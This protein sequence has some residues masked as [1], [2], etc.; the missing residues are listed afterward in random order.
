[1]SEYSQGLST[2]GATEAGR[3]VPFAVF[4]FAQPFHSTHRQNDSITVGCAVSQSVSY[5][6]VPPRSHPSTGSQSGST[7]P[8][9]TQVPSTLLAPGG[10][11]I[12]QL[13]APR[14]S[15]VRSISPSGQ[16]VVS[17]AFCPVL[18]GRDC[19]RQS[20]MRRWQLAGCGHADFRIFSH[21]YFRPR[22]SVR[23]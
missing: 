19:D 14:T 20:R 8:V 10:Y 11:S 7:A 5:F 17:V 9:L 1:M 15:Q 23:K 4:C 22:A 2:H 3:G 13:S 21:L 16:G 12:S 6:T 18:L